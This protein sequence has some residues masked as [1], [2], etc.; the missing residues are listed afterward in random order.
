MQL[1]R[2]QGHQWVRPGLLPVPCL[3]NL[4]YLLLL[5]KPQ[6]QLLCG[7]WENR[8]RDDYGQCSPL[9]NETTTPRRTQKG[10]SQGSIILGHKPR[11]KVWVFLVPSSPQHQPAGLQKNN[12]CNTHLCITGVSSHTG[13][14]ENQPDPGAPVSVISTA[15]DTCWT[16]NHASLRHQRRPARITDLLIWY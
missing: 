8:T 4:R 2:A 15:L 12:Q 3:R 16:C 10:T 1:C 13:K 14:D 5:I 6:N 11:M 7:S 9:P